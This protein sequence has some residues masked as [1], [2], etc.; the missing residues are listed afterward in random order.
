MVAFTDRLA[1]AWHAVCLHWHL[2]CLLLLHSN[3]RHTIFALL[4]AVSVCV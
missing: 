1:G 3:V 4:C 2:I